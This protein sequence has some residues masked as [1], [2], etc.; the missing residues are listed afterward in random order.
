[1][2]AVKIPELPHTDFGQNGNV[3]LPD[4]NRLDT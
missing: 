2:G 4:M 3:L 1:M